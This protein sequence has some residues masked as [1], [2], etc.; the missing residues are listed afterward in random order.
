M[1]PR[2]SSLRRV[3]KPNLQPKRPKLAEKMK[4]WLAPKRLLAALK[5]K[6]KTPMLVARISKPRAAAARTKMLKK[7]KKKRGK[8]TRTWRWV[9][10]RQLGR[11]VT[12]SRV[13]IS[14][15]ILR[16]SWHI[17]QCPHHKYPNPS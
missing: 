1:V 13:C 9:M 14:N 8:E 2:K 17:R 15:L 10:V 12:S 6:M 16:S 7:R 3:L 11:M 4:K 5:R